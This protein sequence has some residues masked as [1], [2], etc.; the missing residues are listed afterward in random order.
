[1]RVGLDAYGMV[2]ASEL[3]AWSAA[4]PGPD[5]DELL[6]ILIS[7]RN[8]PR[9]DDRTPDAIAVRAR[10]K[11]I[12]KRRLADLVERSAE[13]AALIERSIERLN[14]T[15]GQPRSFAPIDR[16]LNAQS[17]RLAHWR[18]ASEEIN[19]RRFFDIN[20]LAAL[21]VEDPVVFDEVHRFVFDLV[22]R[23]A[24]TGLRIDHVDGL[25]DPRDYLR[26]LQ[27]RTRDAR[28]QFY[29]VVEKIL[30]AGEQLTPDWP[31]SGT[32]GYEF[33]A[34][35]NNLFVDRRHERAFDDIYRRFTRHRVSFADLAYISKKQV[36]HE[37]MSG[38]INSLGHQLNRF[39]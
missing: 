31:V 25:F 13:V 2:F 11:E 14:G 24:V 7:S 39:S 1:G 3:D 5:A 10:E 38:D 18:V 34:M 4:H 35:V 19:Y 28:E 26:R 32:T 22:E 20:Q 30:G 8:L 6:S 17:Y 23:G 15:P 36:L 29:V 27:E 33:G 12:V 9:R 16:L 37:T 21:R